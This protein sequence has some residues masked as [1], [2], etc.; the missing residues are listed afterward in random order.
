M[1]SEIDPLL[2]IN[3]LLPIDPLLPKIDPL[4]LM[5]DPLSRKESCGRETM[6]SVSRTCCAV[7]E[8]LLRCCRELFRRNITKM[9]LMNP[10]V[11]EKSV[12]MLE[13]LSESIVENLLLRF[14]QDVY[15]TELR[16][17]REICD[18]SQDSCRETVRANEVA[19]ERSDPPVSLFCRTNPRSSSSR[20]KTISNGRI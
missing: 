8:N 15:R 2:S 18:D 1:P 6:E 10:F 12:T 19:V 5:I 13:N 16:S 17:C 4:L 7:A 20:P 14:C 9:L 11:V 3:P